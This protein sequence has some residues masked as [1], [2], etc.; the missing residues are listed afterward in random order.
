MT[1]RF[2]MRKVSQCCE[3]ARS[4]YDAEMVQPV[5]KELD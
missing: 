2:L 1:M 5:S 4:I 3:T